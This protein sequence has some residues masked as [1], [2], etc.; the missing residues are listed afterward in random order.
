MVAYYGLDEKLGNISFYDSTG[1]YEQSLQKPYGEQTA[2]IIDEQVRLLVKQTYEKTKALL[3]E[4]RDKL[5]TL[6]E[7]LLE[8]E[9]VLREDLERIFGPRP[10]A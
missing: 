3:E 10:L 7:L 8:K 6:A 1:Q 2:Q 9:V 5:Q 4:H